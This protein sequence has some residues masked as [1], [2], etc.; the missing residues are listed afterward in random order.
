MTIVGTAIAGVVAILAGTG[1]LMGICQLS[2]NYAPNIRLTSRDITGAR[3]Y[4]LII[5]LNIVATFVTYIGAILLFSDFLIRSGPTLWYDAIIAIL[6]YDLA[7][8]W[9]HR[10]MHTKFL[11]RHLHGWHH[12]CKHPT[13][14]DGL[15]QRPHET[16]LALCLLL[17]CIAVVGPVSITSFVLVISFHTVLNMLDHANLR[18]GMK[19]FDHLMYAHDL[20]HSKRDVNFG[21]TPLWDHVFGT[22]HKRLLQ[23]KT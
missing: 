4:W 10:A 14:F 22:T 9:M 18:T 1:I 12:R 3:N 17:A 2:Y 8:Y 19:W 20:H 6:L 23:T 16:V 7:Y 13:A 11:M 21:L 15:Y 5:A